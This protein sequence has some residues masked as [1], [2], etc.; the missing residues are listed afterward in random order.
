MLLQVYWCLKSTSEFTLMPFK[1]SQ[2]AH[3]CAYFSSFFQCFEP[4]TSLYCSALLRES[5]FFPFWKSGFDFLAF[6]CLVGGCWLTPALLG[7]QTSTRLYSIHRVQLWNKPGQLLNTQQ[8][9]G[10]ERYLYYTHYS[11]WPVSWKQP[12]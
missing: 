6:D 3:V 8:M 1:R 4:A 9:C 2:R 10:R 11:K 5:N 12:P 7:S